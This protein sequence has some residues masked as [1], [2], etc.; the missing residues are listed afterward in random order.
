MRHS[1]IFQRPNRRDS[2]GARKPVTAGEHLMHSEIA[3]KFRIRFA[4][5]DDAEVI[6]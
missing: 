5:L 2:S 6:S 3:D 1:E 4:T